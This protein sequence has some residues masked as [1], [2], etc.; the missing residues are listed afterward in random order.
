MVT[1]GGLI[2]VVLGVEVNSFVTHSFSR[3]HTHTLSLEMPRT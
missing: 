1:H 3:G 2:L